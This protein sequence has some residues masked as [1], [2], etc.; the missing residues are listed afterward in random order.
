MCCIFIRTL[1]KLF[2]KVAWDWS[3]S[4]LT[5]SH[6]STGLIHRQACNQHH[7]KVKMRTGTQMEY[8]DLAVLSQE[9][10]D[11][12]ISRQWL[13]NFLT[14]SEG[15]STNSFLS[16]YKKCCI[17]CVPCKIASWE[18]VH[19]WVVYHRQPFFHHNTVW[20]FILVVL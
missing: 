1:K 6:M 9:N 18:S 8:L 17:L 2:Y 12:A 3:Y 19:L 13:E 16:T 5:H 10:K 15:E 14:W 20:R 7:S 11:V 4:I